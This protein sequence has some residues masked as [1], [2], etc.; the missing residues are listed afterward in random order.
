MPTRSARISPLHAGAAAT[1][2]QKFLDLA[3]LDDIDAQPVGGAGIAPGNGIVTRDAGTGLPD[4]AMD[5]I[6]G[7]RRIIVDRHPALDL[8]KVQKAGIDA[9][10]LHGIDHAGGHLHLGGTGDHLHHA[11]LRQHDVVVQLPRQPLVERQREVVERR[12]FGIEIVRADRR[13]VAA[14]IAAAQPAAL[15]HRDIAQAMGP[16]EIVGRGKPLPAAADDHHI[17]A[18]L[19]LRAA[20]GGAPALLAGKPLLEQRK[21]RIVPGHRWPR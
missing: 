11:A 13:G 18:R 8:G 6:A 14:G 10:D 4:R 15:D 21:R 1:L 7:L 2:D 9:V 12:A 19:G 5:R 16:G 17:V 20:P 3:L